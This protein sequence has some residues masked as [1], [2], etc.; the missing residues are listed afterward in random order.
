M[1]L[2]ADAILVPSRSLYSQ[3]WF[4][5]GPP[6]GLTMVTDP[7]T[8]EDRV[9]PAPGT[10]VG[11]APEIWLGWFWYQGEGSV[12]VNWFVSAAE[13][14]L[15]RAFARFEESGRAPLCER[16][17]PLLALPVVGTGS[18][19]AKPIA[20]ELLSALMLM[21]TRFAT[22]HPVDVCL[23]TKSQRM[24][25]AAQSIR[26]RL[27]PLSQQTAASHGAL[28]GP[29]LL[30]S[31]ARLAEL[32]TS[33]QLVLFLG[34]GTSRTNNMPGWSE[35]LGE[36]AS[37][38]GL[39]DTEQAQFSRLELKDQAFV[40]QHRLGSLELRKAAAAQRSSAPTPTP[41]AVQEAGRAALQRLAVERLTTTQYSVTHA[42]LATIPHSATVTTNSDTCYDSACAAAGSRVVK[43]PYETVA[44]TSDEPA[45][46]WVLKLHGDVDHPE[47]IV[48]TY[49]SSNPYGYE[50][51][52]LSGI[53]QA[54]LITKHMCF[55]GFSL[56]DDAFNQIAATVRRAMYPAEASD[57]TRLAA[58]AAIGADTATRAV[59]EAAGRALE[60]FDLEKD[61]YAD[62]ATP[63][64]PPQRAASSP[65]SR[66]GGKGGGS[67]SFGSALTLSDR[68]FMAELWPELEAVPM[69]EGLTTGVEDFA[70][71]QRRLEV[72][73]DRVSLLTTDTSTHLLDPTYAGTFIDADLALKDEIAVLLD[74]LRQE[75][76]TSTAEAFE[77]VRNM[78]TQLGLPP[79][80][81]PGAHE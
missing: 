36:L 46:R 11:D 4:P 53:I 79:E 58:T 13:Q 18:S 62:E 44:P 81:M 76:G 69:G 45:S 49:S 33:G 63:S 59:A 67:G 12:P 27:L 34:S 26:L 47:D 68:P 6:E 40:L 2:T 8:L 48:L 7:F 60:D 38:A 10:R 14:F 71:R 31:A 29:R 78:L 50:R 54:L 20:G 57:P 70:M 19:G 43:L 22:R 24:F 28:L 16:Q 80:L 5:D 51:E 61:G 73:L 37:L 74:T 55:V 65:R 52:A 35:L 66:S 41:E 39:T 30:R 56:R 23:V 9:H 1:K 42:L 15:T 77:E 21:L 75:P 72:L 17:L 25:S 32:A 64:A 3:K